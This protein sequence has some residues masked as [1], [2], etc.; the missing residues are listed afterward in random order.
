MK[1]IIV[2]L[3]LLTSVASHA[4]E[5]KHEFSPQVMLDNA[6]AMRALTL[7]ANAGDEYEYWF[8]P[9]F[10][11]NG[12]ARDAVIVKKME[13]DDNGNFD[14]VCGGQT[15]FI[16]KSFSFIERAF[17]QGSEGNRRVVAVFQIARPAPRLFPSSRSLLAL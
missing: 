4:L 16:E 2:T 11:C 5:T 10:V 12:E 8:Y 17:A 9:N 15:S 14:E 13:F 1:K 7:G 6:D 3:L